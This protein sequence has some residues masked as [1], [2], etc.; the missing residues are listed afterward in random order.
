MASVSVIIGER[1]SALVVGQVT[2]DDDLRRHDDTDK[3]VYEICVQ[4]HLAPHCMAWFGGLTLAPVGNQTRLTGELADQAALFALLRR[5][6][7]LGL[8]L[9][10]VRRLDALDTP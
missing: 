7:D 6:R 3:A 4:G 1:T 5:I 10:S 9:V 8:P 2:M